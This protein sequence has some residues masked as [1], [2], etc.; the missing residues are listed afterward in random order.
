[1]PKIAV[2]ISDIGYRCNKPL[3]YYSSRLAKKHGY[4]KSRKVNL[5]YKY[6]A[7][8]I[9]GNDENIQEAYDALFPQAEAAL[10]DID[11]TEYKDILFI[12]KGIGTIIAT[13]YAKKYGLDGAKHILFT[14]LVQTFSFTTDNSIAFMGYA[15]SWS[16]ANEIHDL[17]SR[18]ILACHLY[19]KCNHSL[20][21]DD[22]IE[23][24]DILKGIMLKTQ[25]F[26][27]KPS[28]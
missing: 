21:C 7:V 4:G 18:H 28:I 17:S 25:D 16:N 2:C 10:S 1:M 23:N 13:S 27:K 22:A 11:W 15:D 26:I 12:S 14:P 9:R 6:G 19:D 3:L 24:I 5:D 8:N 20:E